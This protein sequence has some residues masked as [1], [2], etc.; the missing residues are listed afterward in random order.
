MQVQQFTDDLY[1]QYDPYGGL[2]SLP[3]VTPVTVAPVVAPAIT[4]DQ[5]AAISTQQL[6]A[7][8]TQQAPAISTDGVFGGLQ[9]LA[10]NATIPVN[11]VAQPLTVEQ[12]YQKILGRN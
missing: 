3:T 7:I 4:A 10:E 11:D 2:A 8:S 1:D 6:P 12:L 5:N 9:S